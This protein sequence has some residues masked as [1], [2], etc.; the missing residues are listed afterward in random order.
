MIRIINEPKKPQRIFAE[1]K[2]RMLASNLT[3]LR[4]ELELFI[5][6]VKCFLVLYI[7][8]LVWFGMVWFGMVWL[9]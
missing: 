8:Q 9:P 2:S 7:F 4:C 6:I 1:G 5:N 3:Y